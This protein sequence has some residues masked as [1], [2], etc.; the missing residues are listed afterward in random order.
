MDAAAASELDIG[1]H[2]AKQREGA[3]VKVDVVGRSDAPNLGD[4]HKV[5]APAQ[6][7]YG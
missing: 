3:L 6:A 4:V 2:I 5:A 7:R 1:H